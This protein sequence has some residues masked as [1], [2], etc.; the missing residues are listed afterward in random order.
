MSCALLHSDC[1]LNTSTELLWQDVS[2]LKIRNKIVWEFTSMWHDFGHSWRGCGWVPVRGSLCL[3]WRETHSKG[4]HPRSPTRP[5]EDEWS[6]ENREVDRTEQSTEVGESRESREEGSRLI[7]A[8]CRRE[9]ELE[10]VDSK[11]GLAN[12]RWWV[13]VPGGFVGISLEW[14]LAIAHRMLGK[15]HELLPSCA[16]S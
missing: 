12:G 15:C 9:Q 13:S 2:I 7:G 1:N 16:W 3:F 8:V 5:K 14:T 10:S 6:Q 4:L 11:A